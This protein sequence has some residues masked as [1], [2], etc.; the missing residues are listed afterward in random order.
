MGELIPKRPWR[1]GFPP[2]P[3]AVEASDLAYVDNFLPFTPAYY[4]TT[5]NEHSSLTFQLMAKNGKSNVL[6]VKTKF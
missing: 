5:V 3:V 2:N 4:A 6:I 1:T